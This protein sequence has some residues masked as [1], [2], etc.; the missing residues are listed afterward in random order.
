MSKNWKF[1]QVHADV[2]LALE[3]PEGARAGDVVQVGDAGQLA[4]MIT[5]RATADGPNAP[6]L[7]EGYASVRL[8]PAQGVIEVPVTDAVE[9]GAAVFATVDVDG[10]ITYGSTGDYAIGRAVEPYGHA[11]ASGSA[12]VYLGNPTEPAAAE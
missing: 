5:E 12:F 11:P 9:A 8:L 7:S 4:Y 6:G 2:T 3:V 1:G 10:S